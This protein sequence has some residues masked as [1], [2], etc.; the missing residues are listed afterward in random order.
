MAFMAGPRQ[1]GLSTLPFRRDKDPGRAYD[2]SPKLQA[3]V[4]KMTEHLSDERKKGLVF[5]NFVDAGLTPYAAALTRAGVP[6]GVFHGGLSDGDRKKLVDDYNAGR[7]RAALLGPSGTEGLSMKGTQLIQL[8]DPHWHPT[9][10]AQAVGRGLRFDS[11]NDLP[12]DLRQVT[13]QRFASRLPNGVARRLARLTGT[14]DPDVDRYVSGVADR[15]QQSN[16]LILD[17]LKG[18]GEKRGAAA[19]PLPAL[20]LAKTESDR[21]N[22]AAKHAILRRLLR[23]RPGEFEVDDAG[24]RVVGLTHAPTGF[25]LHLPATALPT[26]LPPSA[27]L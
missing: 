7:I 24:G 14:A 26:A 27:P 20:L 16:Q 23:E 11:H 5:S 8:L 25:R 1:V 17:L 3:A 12:E 10:S 22:Y 19:S 18:V 6:H 21:K 2:Q 13:V 9:R 15:K 4:A